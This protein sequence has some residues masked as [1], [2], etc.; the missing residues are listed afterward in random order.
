MITTTKIFIVVFLILYYNRFRKVWGHTPNF[1]IVILN[2][3][4]SFVWPRPKLHDF[5]GWYPTS[6][7]SA[8]SP[9]HTFTSNINCFFFL[10]WFKK[11]KIE[12]EIVSNTKILGGGGTYGTLSG[13]D[14]VE[15][16]ICDVQLDLDH[17]IVINFIKSNP[18]SSLTS[19]HL[20]WK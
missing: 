5:T 19:K 4:S 12:N 7:T 1:T 14:K 15:N 2:R 16:Y 8:P 9:V 18:W 11:A 6:N 17:F 10:F 3:M 13:N 20:R